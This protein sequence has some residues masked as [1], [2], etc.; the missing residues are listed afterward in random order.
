[1]YDKKEYQNWTIIAPDIGAQNMVN[2]ICEDGD[3]IHI[4]DSQVCKDKPLLFVG[5]HK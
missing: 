3:G 4:D 2:L 5:H 1:M